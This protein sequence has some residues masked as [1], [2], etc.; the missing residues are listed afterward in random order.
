MLRQKDG[1]VKKLVG[2]IALLCVLSSS[3]VHA[4]DI[5]LVGLFKKQAVFMLGQEQ[6]LLKQGKTHKSGLKLIAVRKSSA[7]IEY[8]GKRQTIAM[9]RV[10]SA[11]YSVADKAEVSIRPD[12]RGSYFTQ[13]RI[14]GRSTQILIDTGATSVAL[15]GADARRLGLAYKR[16]Q[17]TTVSTASGVAPAYQIDLSRVSLG[18]LTVHQVRAVVIEGHYPQVPLLGMS[19]LNQVKMQEEG[20]ILYLREK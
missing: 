16:G 2:F 1:K 9:N 10:I 14:N 3:Q 11:E 17:A 12:Q 13:A 8:Q 20:N 19:F 18:A 5:M 6:V 15:S 7:L 4:L